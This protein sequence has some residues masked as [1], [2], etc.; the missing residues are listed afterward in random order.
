[1][2]IP[3]TQAS[4]MSATAGTITFKSG[5]AGSMMTGLQVYNISVQTNQITIKRNL[6]TSSD[7]YGK[8]IFISDNCSNIIITQCYLRYSSG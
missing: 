1:M 2:R 4:P 3:N 8:S 6:A 5:S 7:D